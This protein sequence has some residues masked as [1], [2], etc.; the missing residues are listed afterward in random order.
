MQLSMQK[1][2]YLG[3]LALWQDKKTTD[4][5]H[6][7]DARGKSCVSVLHS[8]SAALLH[9][10]WNIRFRTFS[11][12]PIGGSVREFPCQISIM[13]LLW[14]SRT[15]AGPKN[16]S[17]AAQ[18][19]LVWKWVGLFYHSRKVTIH[20]TFF[21]LWELKVFLGF[22]CNAA[23]TL[24]GDIC[25]RVTYQC[26]YTY[27]IKKAHDLVEHVVTNLYIPIMGSMFTICVRS[28]FLCWLSQMLRNL[29]YTYTYI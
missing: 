26:D 9:I 15:A 24:V 17:K 22:F 11:F 28:F 7:E 13:S 21:R 18:H 12:S 25:C 2:I 23:T 5:P 8:A 6:W 10:T 3:W 27:A 29:T 16:M 14:C 19:T 4:E 20:C 1:T